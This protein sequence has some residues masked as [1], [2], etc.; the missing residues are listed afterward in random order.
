M[1]S[2]RVEAGLVCGAAVRAAGAVGR[3]RVWAA[4]SMKKTLSIEY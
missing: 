3:P 2:K 1:G 4:E